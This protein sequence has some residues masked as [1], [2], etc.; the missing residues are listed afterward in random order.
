MGKSNG[1]FQP[2]CYLWAGNQTIICFDENDSKF[3]YDLSQ[4]LKFLLEHVSELLLWGFSFL[5]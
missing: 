4:I 1:S 2:L 3:S 5:F